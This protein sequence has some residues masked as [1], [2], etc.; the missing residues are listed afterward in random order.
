M[1]DLFGKL[2]VKKNQEQG[3]EA[4]CVCGELAI[5]IPD[6]KKEIYLCQKCNKLLYYADPAPSLTNV[7]PLSLG[8]FKRRK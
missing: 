7:I 1:L 8:F 2:K 6:E 3:H 4:R 5:R